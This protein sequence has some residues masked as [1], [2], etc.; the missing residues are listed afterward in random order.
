MGDRA[1]R[2]AAG[3]RVPVLGPGPGVVLAPA[4]A[5]PTS[6][7]IGVDPSATL[8]RMA[9]ARCAPF[10]ADGVVE[11][12]ESGAEAAGGPVASVEA[13]IS[14]NNVMLWDQPVA[15]RSCIGCCVRAAGWCSACTGMCWAFHPSSCRP[16]WR[17]AGSPS[18]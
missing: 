10:V 9:A 4:A 6:Q 11:V 13:V 12:R 16:T 8:R 18:R 3:Q 5:G 1:G 15:L 17:P 2:P 14:V 7:V